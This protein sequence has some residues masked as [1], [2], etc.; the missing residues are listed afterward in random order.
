MYDFDIFSFTPK[1]VGVS[2]RAAILAKVIFTKLKGGM[3]R[4]MPATRPIVH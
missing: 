1:P 2:L 3:K 4:K